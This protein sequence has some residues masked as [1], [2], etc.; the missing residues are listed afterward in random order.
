MDPRVLGP[1]WRYLVDFHITDERGK[2][3]GYRSL[4]ELRRR[5]KLVMLRRDRALVRDQLPDRIEQRRDVGLSPKQAEIH[6][7]AINTAGR[8][9][10]IIKRRP[11]TPSEQNRLMAALQRTR[12]ACNAAGLVDK[13]TRGSPK[14]DELA[15]ILEEGCQLAGLKAVVFSQWAQMG[16]M[17]EELVRR[18]GLGGVRLHGGVPSARRGKLLDRFHDDDACQVFISTD[19]GGTG[20]NLQWVRLF[21]NE[22][23]LVQISALG[24][25][26]GRFEELGTTSVFRP[27]RRIPAESQDPDSYADVPGGN[28]KRDSR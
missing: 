10:Q 3:L 26:S 17:V 13:E 14:L 21:C 19:A 25:F 12:M 15:S 24:A 23:L 16:E 4:S 11:L 18:M 7:D 22:A 8:L 28:E 5:L 27:P 20:L 2:V 6:D 9:A 1:L